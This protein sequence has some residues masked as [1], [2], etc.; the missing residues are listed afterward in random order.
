[1]VDAHEHPFKRHSGAVAGFHEVVEN[2]G[3]SLKQK[4]S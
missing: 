1:L 4:L 2:T 3:A